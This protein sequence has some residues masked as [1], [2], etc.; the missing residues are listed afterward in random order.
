MAYVL[1]FFV[2]DGSMVK[3]RRGAHF[4]EFQITDKDL[5]K[6]IRKLFGS[7][8]K[9]SI[10]KNKS[11]KWKTVYRLQIGSKEIFNDL[12]RIGLFPHKAKRIRLP[13]I[14]KEYF[15]HFVRG[16]FDGDGNVTICT[17]KRK[18][19]N[20]KPTT[21]LQSGFTSGSKKFL[22]DL[23]N[24]LLKE[25]IVKG[26][27]FYYSN[28]GWRLYFSINDSRKLYNYLYAGLNKTDKLFLKRKKIV[29]EKYLR[30]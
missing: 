4:I 17:Y 18:A 21:I 5:L 27:T 13:N 23:K 8:H 26:G 1:G 14:P 22:A 12:L 28:N 30:A 20:N 11:N 25:K 16:Y 2:A 9:I 7:N 6:K 10:R 3:N 24:K 15:S 29:F 19:R